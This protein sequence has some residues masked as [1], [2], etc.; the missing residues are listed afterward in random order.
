MDKVKIQKYFNDTSQLLTALENEIR[1]THATPFDNIERNDFTLINIPDRYIRKAD[2]FRIEYKLNEIISDPNIINNIAYSLQL[3]D[4]H[5]YF[6]NRFNLFGII[7][8]LYLKNA[9]INVFSIEEAIFYGTLITLNKYCW[10]NGKVCSKNANCEFYVNTRSKLT[11]YSLIE[12][13]KDKLN[14]HH[15]RFRE[16]IFNLKEI[17]DNVHIEDV[18]YSEWA[19]DD[20][21][22]FENY[23]NAILTLRY[24]KIQLH[25]QV[26]EFKEKRDK[27]CKK[28]KVA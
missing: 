8:N 16:I 6:I 26:F 9:I 3:S 27:G 10:F 7:K 15:D 11:F 14:F 5:N 4:L 21:Y 28:R 19:A 22:S 23:N 25:K 13:F 12:T 1:L 20:R 24:I 2:Y 17:R 18:K